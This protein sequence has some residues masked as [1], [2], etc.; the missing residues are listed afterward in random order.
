[1]TVRKVLLL[2]N[3]KLYEVSEP[4]KEEYLERL[5]GVVRDLHDTL[6]DPD[7]LN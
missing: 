3:P 2:G 6:M 7:L 4:L 1:M 5:A